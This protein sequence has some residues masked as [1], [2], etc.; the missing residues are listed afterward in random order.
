[1]QKAAFMAVCPFE[2]GDSILKEG[3]SKTITDILTVHSLK[4]GR[5]VF[6]YGACGGNGIPCYGSIRLAQIYFRNF[7]Q[8]AY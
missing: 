6:L 2:L 8:Y 7:V 1:M 5:V 3:T 4:T